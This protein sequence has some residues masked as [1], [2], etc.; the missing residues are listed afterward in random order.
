M[1]DA[2]EQ[3]ERTN[4]P[5]GSAAEAG[6][7]RDA[8]RGRRT[9]LRVVFLVITLAALAW[10]IAPIVTN[11]D[12]IAPMLARPGLAVALIAGSLAYAGALWLC[13]APGWWWLTRLYGRT[14]PALPTA[15]VWCRTQIVKY[16]PGNVA[17]YLG[18]QVLGR[19]LGLHHAEM[20]AAS[21]LELVS[22][23]GAAAMIGAA[24]LA[25]GAGSVVPGDA[26]PPALEP[27]GGAR[28]GVAL[29]VIAA[30][31]VVA[32]LA[33][34]IADAL[35]RRIGFLKKRMA[36]L[37]RLSA[38]RSVLLLGPALAV[39]IVFLIATG[40]LLW[41]LCLAATPEG[42]TAPS[43]IRAVWIYAVAW[44]VGTVAPGA[45]A[46]AGVR[47]AIITLELASDLGRPEAAAIALGLRLVTTLGDAVAF[48]VSG[49]VPIGAAVVKS[50]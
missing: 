3:P 28:L 47:E 49:V 50:R 32:L 6:S 22:I 10:V 41:W 43:A 7:G 2:P 30:L 23:L 11:W 25:L 37:P 15:A 5:T 38:T 34:P 24:G 26:A 39:H 36:D 18:R 21:L 1:A 17:H 9:V 13:M 20:A 33:W 8:A 12:A 44:A 45:P 4:S 31:I 16:L 42:A 46:G 27:D 35:A 48:G 19:R 14:A 40:L 29:P